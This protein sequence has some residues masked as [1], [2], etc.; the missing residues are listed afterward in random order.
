MISL[1]QLAFFKNLENMSKCNFN[2]LE[3]N[4]SILGTLVE[5][6]KEFG[7]TTQQDIHDAIRA[8]ITSLQSI[9][10]K[11]QSRKHLLA[12]CVNDS[13]H[14]FWFQNHSEY[15]QGQPQRYSP[16]TRPTIKFVWVLNVVEANNGNCHQQ[17][18]TN[19]V[20]R[21]QTHIPTNLTQILNGN[22]PPEF[23]L[24]CSGAHHHVVRHVYN[25]V[26]GSE[27]L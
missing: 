7:K 21:P 20:C 27:T 5:S 24:A 17:L 12:V 19:H 23:R 1:K 13:I 25:L 15:V 14:Y 2:F 11:A 16:Y 8:D 3:E 10:S 6:F 9:G 22:C 18:F 26:S 4:Q